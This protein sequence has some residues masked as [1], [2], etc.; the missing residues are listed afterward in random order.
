MP[1]TLEAQSAPHARNI[2][3]LSL[4]ALHPEKSALVSCECVYR[5]A[6]GELDFIDSP[7]TGPGM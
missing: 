1:K 6:I 2:T 4:L 3:T 7:T 5:D